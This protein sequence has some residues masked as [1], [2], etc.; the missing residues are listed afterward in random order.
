MQQ[1]N[2]KIAI[3]GPSGSGKSTLAK[4]LSK[5]FGL[6][7]ID[8]GALYR[9]VGL[10]IKKKGLA[11]TDT[12]NIIASLPEITIEM[13]LENGQGA[14]Y[15]NGEKVGT[16]IRTPESSIYASDVSKIPEVR[17]FL[18]SLQKDIAAKNGVA[19]DGRDIGT[20]I[21][22]D[23]DVKLFLVASDADRAK[24]RYEELIAA[25]NAV[26]Y[27]EVLSDVRWRDNND[28]T[29]K[30]APAV[31]AADAIM[32]DNSG[33]SSEETFAAAMKIVKDK[34]GL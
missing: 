8:T 25:G 26:S 2:I 9:T 12:E 16:E 28:K 14:V 10:Y 7:Y 19:M 20:V 27:E 17:K 22:P 3:D 23:A 1:K 11:S 21:L 13:R 30:I 5:E 4:K 24:R 32:L 31:P 15:L 29:R 33:M 6:I 34:L 18:L